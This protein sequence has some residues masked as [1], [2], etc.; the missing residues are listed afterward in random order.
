MARHNLGVVI[1]FEFTRTVK[2]RRFW[3]TTLAI[4]AVLAVVFLLIFVSN[5]TTSVNE[6]AQRN[7]KITFTYTD[8]SGLIPAST[9]ALFG[10]QLAT[11]PG[12]ALNDVRSGRSEAYFAYP[13]DLSRDP[14]K[15]YGADK[16]I[17]ENGKYDAVAR[18][19][20]TTAAEQKIG[21]TQLTAAVSGTVKIE[22]TTFKDG[23]LAGGVG[24]VVP[25]LLFLLI[26]Y[27]SIILL[28]NQM[29]NSTL[30]EK[31]N[32]VTEMILT[33]LDP[34]TLIIGKVIAVFMVGL[35]QLLVFMTPFGIGY[36]FFREQLS[37]P[38]F[39][40]AHLTFE[41][42]PMITGA[43]LLV[44]GFTVFTGTLVAIGAVMPT[45]KEAG[46]V[47]GSIIALIFVPLYTVSLI[48]S[49]PH[50][51]I[52]QV[53]TY[54]PLSAPVTA[55][56]RNGFGTLNPV[57]SVAVIV[58]LFA[59]GFLTLRLAVHLFRYGSI[60]YSRKLSIRGTFGR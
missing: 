36:V 42:G 26:F 57:E 18:R 23:Q 11:D 58:E 2:K 30:E 16:G 53:F 31:E 39:D 5:S 14:I 60:E 10:G 32:R 37:L 49:D 24:A 40:L 20:L 59:V 19:L 17:F 46:A 6:G 3:A 21:S 54:F 25:P 12:T 4:P 55:L 38:S 51:L 8:S 56:L 9:A 28:S 1:G 27:V 47:F 29:L 52:V 43:L 44:G 34:T 13:A 22:T 15:V 7:A 45:A 35:V 41:P 50:A 48:V 33:T